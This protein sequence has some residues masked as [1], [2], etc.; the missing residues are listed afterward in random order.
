MPSRITVRQSTTSDKDAIAYLS[1]VEFF[2]HQHLDWR[3]PSDWL[4]HP[5]FQVAEYDNEIIACL[6]APNEVNDVAWVQLFACSALYS[7][8]KIFNVL[9]KTVLSLYP[10]SVK[11]VCSLGLHSWFIDL[12]EKNSFS[13]QQNIIIFEW[14]ENEVNESNQNPGISIQKVDFPDLPEIV[15]LDQRCFPPIWQVPMNSMIEAFSQAGY[16]TKAVYD[17]K[18]VGYQLSTDSH[19]TAHLARLAVDP[20]IQGKKIG[21]S[22]VQDLQ[23][24]YLALEINSISVNTQDDNYSS[25]ALYRKMGFK[26]V[27]EKYPVYKLEN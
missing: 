19:S 23:K 3:P 4:G 26:Q 7:K 6:S 20:I 17:N 11:Y 8:E 25:Q 12:L 18:I 2:V 13:T 16:F 14:F 1:D 15:E 21:R 5:S 9:L 22:L 27:D 24:H 10:A